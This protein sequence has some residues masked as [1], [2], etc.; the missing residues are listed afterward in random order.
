MI[1]TIEN[2]EKDMQKYFDTVR[3]YATKEGREE[4]LAA[5]REEGLV[6]GRKEGLAEGKLEGLAEGRKEGLA[7]GKLKGLA[8]GRQEGLVLGIND[9]KVKAIELMIELGYPEEEA[10][11][12]VEEKFK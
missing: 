3:R 9:S 4:G 1:F 10:R 2:Y 12:M 8:E 7:E 6:E 11:K 5:G